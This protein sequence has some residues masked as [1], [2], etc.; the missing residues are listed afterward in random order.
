MKLNVNERL[1]IVQILPEK[2][3]FKTMTTID[4]LKKFI[5]LSEEEVKEFEFGQKFVGDKETL[6]WNKKGIEKTEVEISELGIE[7]IMESF[8]KL[9]KAETL[10][11]QQFGVYKYLKEELE[12]PD[13]KK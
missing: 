12:K 8:E 1:V 13:D 2:G 11:Y 4:K 5:Y 9:D 6:V 3:N 10:T 7:L